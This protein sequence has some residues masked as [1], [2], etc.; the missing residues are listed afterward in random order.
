MLT[1]AYLVRQYFKSNL[2]DRLATRPFLDKTE[3]YWLIYQLLRAVEVVH[4]ENIFHGDIKPENVMVTSW[5]WLILTDFATYKPITIPEDDPTDFQYFF[6]SSGRRRCYIAPERFV[7]RNRDHREASSTPG[8]EA[9][10]QG[11]LRLMENDGASRRWASGISGVGGSSGGNLGAIDD[12]ASCITLGGL[13]L[14]SIESVKAMDVF[15]LGCTIAEILLDGVPLIDLPGIL[16]YRASYEADI[17]GAGDTSPKA[18]PASLPSKGKFMDRLDHALSPSAVAVQRIKDPTLR[19]VICL[20]TARDPN[21]RPSVTEVLRLVSD[22][23]CTV[24]NDI[25]GGDE[26][27]VSSIRA[28]MDCNVLPPFFKSYLYDFFLSAHWQGMLPD[29]RI[30]MLCENYHDIMTELTGSADIEG[31]TFFEA[32]Y[33][34]SGIYHTETNP[35][36]TKLNV[37]IMFKMAEAPARYKYG[38]CSYNLDKEVPRASRQDAAALVYTLGVDELLARCEILLGIVKG[39]NPEPHLEFSKDDHG[40]CKKSVDVNKKSQVDSL[41]NRTSL[42]HPPRA[43]KHAEGLII[44]VEFVCSN[45]RHLRYPLSRITSLLML[46]RMAAL[47]NSEVVLQRIVPFMLLS[48][49]DPV[50]SVRAIAVRALCSTLSYVDEFLPHERLIFI[51]SVFPA[52]NV[53]SRDNEIV[54]RVSFVECL[55]RFAELSKYFLDKAHAMQ[56][57]KLDLDRARSNSA[58]G[59]NSSDLRP[60]G[61]DEL[62]KKLVAVK[63]SYDADLKELQTVVSRW[64][65]IILSEQ[66][67]MESQRSGPSV[68]SIL[69]HSSLCKKI[70]LADIVMLC[71]FFGTELTLDILLSQILTFLNDQDWELRLAFCSALP[72]VC[73]FV[74]ATF[75]SAYI[76]PC[77]ENALVDVEVMVVSKALNIVASLI[78]LQLLNENLIERTV[79]LFACLVVHPVDA[80]RSGAVDMTIAAYNIF[81]STS[82]YTLVRPALLPF[83]EYDI[84]A[85]G[86]DITKE[87]IRKALQPPVSAHGYRI[88]MLNKRNE[89]SAGS[90][91]SAVSLN[92]TR[93]LVRIDP[94]STKG[95]STSVASLSG[96]DTSIVIVDNAANS[97]NRAPLVPGTD[98]V[99]DPPVIPG[100][101]SVD[102]AAASADSL[103]DADSIQGEQLKIAAMSKY[104]EQAATEMNTKTLQWRNASNQSQA[105][106]GRSPYQYLLEAKSVSKEKNNSRILDIPSAGLIPESSVHWLRIPHQKLSV[107]IGISEDMRLQ[108]KDPIKLAEDPQL[109]H[110]VFGI[111]TPAVAETMDVEIDGV[112]SSD[113]GVIVNPNNLSTVR[114][115]SMAV[116]QGISKGRS[117]TA[118]STITRSS[119]V[120]TSSLSAQP[121]TSKEMLNVAGYSFDEAPDNSDINTSIHVANALAEL[122]GTDVILKQIKALK[123]PPLPRDF[124]SLRQ[125]D[126]RKY[127]MFTEQLDMS[128]AIDPQSRALW[129]PKDAVQLASLTEHSQ[130]V[131]RLAVAQ[132]QS[133][134]VSAS[135][136]KT[137]RVWQIS[138]LE[139]NAYPRSSLTY[140]MHTGRLTDVAT[141]ENSHSVATACEDGSVHVWRVDITKRST[142]AGLSSASAG[143]L[144]P[145]TGNANA[146]GAGSRSTLSVS[147]MSEIRNLPPSDGGVVCLQHFNGDSAS[148]L[149][150]CTTRGVVKSWDLRCSNEP[151]EYRISPE[152]GYPTAMTLAPD[153]N[154]LCVGTSK[155]CVALWD[156]RY[157]VMSKLWQHSAAS[158]IHRLASCKTIAGTATANRSNPRDYPEGAY[159]FLASGRAEA[160]VWGLPEG[161]ESIR[162]YR[163]VPA[164]PVDSAHVP[165][166]HAIDP[167][168]VLTEIPLMS[169]H[170]R[171]GSVGSLIKRG[172]PP[173]E[174]SVRSVIGRIS[175]TGASYIITA[176]SDRYIRFWDFSNHSNCFTVSGL[177]S[178]QPRHQYATPDVA[179]FRK[180]L[181]LCFDTAVPTSEQTLQAHLPTRENRGLVNP[182]VGFKV[183]ST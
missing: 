82:S 74:G 49:E 120:T 162:C 65:A 11:D 111:R 172:M 12:R 59:D 67:G 73:A 47:S 17:E 109:I 134:F 21:H 3:K 118:M 164:P 151:F 87:T 70:L 110:K 62:E 160:A 142:P 152:L 132:D 51:R 93:P 39:D 89:L 30:A 154:W 8:S 57:N 108:A 68:F 14:D 22:G 7:K 81:G 72:G 5:N 54:V 183:C 115:M 182:P 41:L 112:P 121:T 103:D 159:L 15:S 176:G 102:G 126:G 167:L 170:A 45:M 55:G 157:N 32:C 130:A 131:S 113:V 71:G 179:P 180:K 166:F 98:H 156:I 171:Y 24:E 33:R 107:G 153:K 52:L 61:N 148:I 77:I 168:P 18:K 44:I 149:T 145:N 165:T 60:T 6:E 56:M 58:A 13:G 40:C 144:S 146:F 129:K 79:Q 31:T 117:S 88:A 64:V 99:A 53:V 181:F 38:F 147:G 25:S 122:S 16:K 101:V 9:A 177:D 178:A 69:S 141:I 169:R 23:V 95:S 27:P 91:V 174:P 26:V 48:L 4:S 128:S 42:L 143:T 1:P 119:R 140:A 84:F 2:Y 34:N 97:I 29:T 76:Y 105:D 96:G 133:F 136:D 10:V 100:A 173:T 50:P 36:E 75:S 90:A 104:I 86:E 127:S 138:G 116:L 19:E 66:Q 155:G 37:D 46:L 106:R 175:G 124:G 43:R 85:T 163:T 92:P 135:A 139:N 78:Q 35:S 125:P 158:N 20:M 28:S 80:I 114:P 137:A 83:L 150:Y 161:G 63:N 123:V 94:S